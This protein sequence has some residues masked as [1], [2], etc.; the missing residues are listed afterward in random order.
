MAAI[1]PKVASYESVEPLCHLHLRLL[2]LV[3]AGACATSVVP[4]IWFLT[5]ITLLIE[6]CSCD[7]QLCI[8]YECILAILRSDMVQFSNFYFYTTT[9]AI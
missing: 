3:S 1:F 2:R 4:Q 5:S 7:I 8:V 6:I 9:I